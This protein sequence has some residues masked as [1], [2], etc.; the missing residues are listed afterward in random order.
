MTATRR[1][2]VA[3]ALISSALPV[4]GQTPVAG[5]CRS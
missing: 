4:R 1:T 2:L 5:L 3:L